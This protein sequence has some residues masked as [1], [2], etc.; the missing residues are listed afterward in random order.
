MSLNSIVLTIGNVPTYE[1]A[2]ISDSSAS[3]TITV[4]DSGQSNFFD[5]LQLPNTTTVP[6]RISDVR[7]SKAFLTMLASEEVL[8]RDWETAEE[9]EAWADL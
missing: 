8:R 7:Y 3:Q 2:C 5:W 4:W 6:F 1:E 9:D